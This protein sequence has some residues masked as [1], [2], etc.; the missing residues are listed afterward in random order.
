MKQIK[1]IFLLSIIFFSCDEINTTND[2]S[3]DFVFLCLLKND[4][5]IQKAYLYNFV[6][7]KDY[8]PDFYIL[9]NDFIH[10]AEII[11]SDG[12]IS[13]QLQ[14]RELPISYWSGDVNEYTYSDDS[15]FYKKILPN[16]KYDL[17]LKVN[18]EI[19][20]G[21]TITPGEFSINS[22]PDTIYRTDDYSYR[23]SWTESNNSFQ[24]LVFLNV[25][26]KSNDGET[27]IVSLKVINTVDKFAIVGFPPITIE[28]PTDPISIY[29]D[30]K[31]YYQYSVEFIV[32]AVDKNYYD[33]I[34]LSRDRAGLSSQYGVFGSSITESC[35]AYIKYKD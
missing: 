3:N 26:Y 2:F 10:D 6:N 33:H 29:P 17:Q 21:S 7:M 23:I 27:S 28:I 34:F 12:I 13:S 1:Y 5:P 8:N 16:K 14:V 22:L 31:K 19:V 4:Q 20:T 25:T 30:Y 15:V 18:N 32:V 24:Y 35:T 11:I 9:N